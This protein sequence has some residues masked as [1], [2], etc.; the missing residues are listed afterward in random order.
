MH[1]RSLSTDHVHRNQDARSHGGQRMTHAVTHAT[2]C[3]LACNVEGRHT[4]ACY[5]VLELEQHLP[6]PPP[7]TPPGGYFVARCRR[8]QGISKAC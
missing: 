8:L 7:L 3:I 5:C 4:T 6:P 2:G 1:T